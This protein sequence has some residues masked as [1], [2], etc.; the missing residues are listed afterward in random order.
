MNPS[1]NTQID[2]EGRPK[3][4]HPT[5]AKDRNAFI[6]IAINTAV[7]ALISRLYFQ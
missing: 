3:K 4:K 1:L 7:C 5:L 6:E 2:R